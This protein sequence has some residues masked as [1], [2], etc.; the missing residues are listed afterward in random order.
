MDES[1]R[2]N[3]S[4]RMVITMEIKKEFAKYA[5][6]NILGIVGM[7]CYIL[8]DTYFISKA[9]GTLGI[10]A[11]NLVLPVYDVIY[12][13]GDMI[14]IGSVIRYS[15][16]KTKNKTEADSYLFNALV[17]ATICGLMFSVIGLFA[18]EPFLQFLGADDAVMAAG[19][20]YTRIFMLFGP[21]FMW[22]LAANAYCRN[23]GAPIVAMMS[24]LIS[25]LFNIVFDYVLMFPFGMGMKGAALATALSPV[26]GILI[27]MIHFLSKKNHVKLKICRPSFKRLLSSCQVGIPAFVAHVSA[28]VVTMTFNYIILLIAGNTAVAAYG[29]IA[30]IALVAVAVFNG[31]ANGSQPLI[32]RDYGLGKDENIHILKRLSF[33]MA[34]VLAVVLYVVI[35]IGTD[36]FIAVFNSES[37][38]ELYRYAHLG[39]RLYFIG[40]LFSGVNIVGA[41]FFSATNEAKNAS[42]ISL[43]RGFILIVLF[44]LILSKL[45]GIIGIWLSYAVGEAVT[46]GVM[47][48]LFMLSKRKALIGDK[49]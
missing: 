15:I 41:S 43:L 2:K 6:L 21:I 16:L 12:G 42:I 8:A 46:T 49:V 47:I 27:C 7:S 17:F 39:I 10:A 22:N 37:N 38:Q 23:D 11:L 20:E 30:N 14:G 31:I 5:S 48:P 4:D 9:Q 18:T 35:F 26:L 13:I 40:I 45:L 32:S 28:G 24:T 29:I 34:L 19:K 44:A 25:S 36:T 1:R 3:S 33:I